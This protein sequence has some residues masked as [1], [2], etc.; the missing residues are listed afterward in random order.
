MDPLGNKIGHRYMWEE[1]ILGLPLRVEKGSL[2]NKFKRLSH[3]IAASVCKSEWF[4]VIGPGVH[5]TE[6]VGKDRCTMQD[7]VDILLKG[8]NE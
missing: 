6:S 8:M 5:G 4:A 3:E 7:V 2:C 1:I